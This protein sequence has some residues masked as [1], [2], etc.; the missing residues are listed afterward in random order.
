MRLFSATRVAF[1]EQSRR[2]TAAALGP[3]EGTRRPEELREDRA[4]H[5]HPGRPGAAGRAFWKQGLWLV[6]PCLQIRRCKP[7]LQVAKACE[8]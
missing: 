4:P 3:G 2:T 1:A 6:S 5:P 8:C 7:W